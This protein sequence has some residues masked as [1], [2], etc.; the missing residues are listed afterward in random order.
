MV[1]NL[2]DFA[3]QNDEELLSG[4][5]WLDSLAQ[6]EGVSFYDKVY[7]VLLKKDNQDKAKIWLQT[8][9]QNYPSVEDKKK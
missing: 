9:S 3:I 2:V 8:K 4:I 7:E 5:K 6:K 1:D